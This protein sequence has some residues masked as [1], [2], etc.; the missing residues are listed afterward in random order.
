MFD[1]RY[2][3]TRETAS[4]NKAF[5]CALI[6]LQW[7]SWLKNTQHALQCQCAAQASIQRLANIMIKKVVQ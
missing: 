5:H 3:N 7:Q 6:L 1:I 2:L 4:G